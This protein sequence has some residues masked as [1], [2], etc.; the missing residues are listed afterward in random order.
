MQSTTLS[1]YHFGSV[2]ARL[3]AFAQMG[4]ARI[5]LARVRDIGMWKLCGSGAGEGFDLTPNTSVFAILAT[6]PDHDSARRAMFGTPVFRRYRDHADEVMTIFLSPTSSR[7]TWAGDAPFDDATDAVEGP[8]AA[9]TRA[10]IEPR[11]AARFWGRVPGIS[12]VIGEDPNVLFKIGIGEVPW[13][14]QITFS[15]WPDAASMAAFARH[16]GPHA[17][18]IRA[19]RTEGWFKEELYARFNVDAVEGTWNG[20]QPIGAPARVEDMRMAAE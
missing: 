4:F 5:G 1:L 7:G 6:W 8:I 13:L 9:L 12:K 10:T 2:Q 17:K 18:A 3:W 20:I 16:D 11:I 14:H 15:I 19:V